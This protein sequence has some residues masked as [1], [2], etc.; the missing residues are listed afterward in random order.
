VALHKQA[1]S[2]LD[3]DDDEDERRMSLSGIERAE[4]KL[5]ERDAQAGAA[6][7]GRKPWWKFW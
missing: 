5:A 6:A 3:K 7:S 1:N 2:Y 4:R